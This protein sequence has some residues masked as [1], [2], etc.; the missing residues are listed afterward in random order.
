MY[1]FSKVCQQVRSCY[2]E[3]QDF[4]IIRNKLLGLYLKKYGTTCIKFNLHTCIVNEDLKDLR[5][6]I[7][8]AINKQIFLI[9]VYRIMLTHI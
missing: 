7:P 8:N 2:K 4:R 6:A 9:I 1:D 5:N 3:Q